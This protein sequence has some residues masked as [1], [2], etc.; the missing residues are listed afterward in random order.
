VKFHQ[1]LYK[2]LG[3]IDFISVQ[4]HVFSNNNKKS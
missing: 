3:G 1:S 4:G 2:C